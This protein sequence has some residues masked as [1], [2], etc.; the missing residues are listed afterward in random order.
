MRHAQSL[1]ATIALTAL[2]CAMPADADILD[3]TGDLTARAVTSVDPACTPS[4]RGVISPSAT[5]GN[6]SLGEFT[7]GHTVCTAGAVGGPVT[8][9]FTID[10]GGDGFF[11]TLDGAASPTATPGM[12]N[13]S[14]L[15]TILGG[16]GRFLNASGT[17]TGI[18]GVDARVRPSTVTLDFNGPI[19]APAVPE[20]ATWA[21]LILGFGMVGWTMRYRA[22]HRAFA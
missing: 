22:A 18:G 15:Y 11:G 8:G 16:T 10:F 13:L 5:V 17:F 19:T 7:Y 21:M 1:K 6:S 9:S 12:S 2:G 14:F 20:P 4:F 3:F